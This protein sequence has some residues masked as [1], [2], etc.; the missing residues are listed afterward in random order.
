MGIIYIH[1]TCILQG[2]RN[3]EYQLNIP[4]TIAHGKDITQVSESAHHKTKLINSIFF[5]FIFN[6]F[7][8]NVADIFSCII[9]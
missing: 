8:H 9:S 3:N 5:Q 2:C 6:M 1:R 4:R 7:L